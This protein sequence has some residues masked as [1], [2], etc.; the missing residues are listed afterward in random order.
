MTDAEI[1]EKL[2]GKW[3]KYWVAHGPF[4]LRYYGK[5]LKSLYSEKTISEIKALMLADGV[6]GKEI[7]KAMSL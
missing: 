4:T 1:K 7:N 3:V 2:F 5:Y 6:D